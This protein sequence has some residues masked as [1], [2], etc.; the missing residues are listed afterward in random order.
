ML[1]RSKDPVAGTV[2]ILGVT[3]NTN[4]VTTYEGLN[5]QPLTASQFFDAIVEGLT[6]VKAKWAPFSDVSQSAKELSL[7]D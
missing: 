1:F 4:S 5:D 7:E 2:S 3:V 6:V